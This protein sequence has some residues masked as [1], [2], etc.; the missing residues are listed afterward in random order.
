MMIVVMVFPIYGCSRR[1]GGIN[2]NKIEDNSS[3]LPLPGVS[4]ST[5]QLEKWRRHKWSTER[6]KQ[7][8]PINELRH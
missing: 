4:D 5:Y 8:Y 7:C 1:I 6:G 3:F 2:M